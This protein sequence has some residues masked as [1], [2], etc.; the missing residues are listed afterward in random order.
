MGNITKNWKR[1]LIILII[2]VGG[3]V[4]LG[5][6]KYYLKWSDSDFKLPAIIFLIVTGLLTKEIWSKKT[7]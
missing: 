5:L 7:N 6:C 2:W 4:I 1:V 3:F